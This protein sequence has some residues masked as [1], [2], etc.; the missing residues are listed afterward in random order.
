MDYETQKIETTTPLEGCGGWY[1]TNDQNR[2]AS[3]KID[4]FVYLRI[5]CVKL[6]HSNGMP[7]EIACLPD[8]LAGWWNSPSQYLNNIINIWASLY[9]LWL[10]QRKSTRRRRS[11]DTLRRNS[12][13]VTENLLRSS[14][15]PPPSSSPTVWSGV[16]IVDGR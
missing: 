7:S 14:W 8:W 9:M 5:H 11:L 3:C 1:P 13:N 2:L 12:L 10:L 6:A 16:S 15:S 4:A